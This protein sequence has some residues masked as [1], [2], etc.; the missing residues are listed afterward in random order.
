MFEGNRFFPLTGMPIWKI[1]RSST[2]LAVWLPEPLTV[3]TWMLK[4]LRTEVTGPRW[5]G[6]GRGVARRG[7]G[8]ISDATVRRPPR[9]GQGRPVAMRRRLCR[10]VDVS[11]GRCVRSGA[12][13]LCWYL[14]CSARPRGEPEVIGRTLG[15]YRLLERI[16]AGGMGVVVL[17]FDERLERRVALKLLP[18]GMLA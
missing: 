11:L 10:S 1:A 4:S 14:A 12:S 8:K 9:G 15:R 5:F 7:W 17:A 2:V 6:R 13:A 16:G 18:Q 3:A